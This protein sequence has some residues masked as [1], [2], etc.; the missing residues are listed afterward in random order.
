[1][2]RIKVFHLIKGLN[3]GGAETLLAE[4]L[5]F[6]D[7]ERFELSYG[8]FHPDLDAL[9]PTLRARGAEVTCFEAGSHAMMPL[10]GLRIARHLWRNR[11]DLV[12]CHLPT[13]GA[14]GRVA[15]ALA[16]VPLVYT[17]HNKVEWYR[18]AT[19]RANAW[20][21]SW[22]RHV[23]AVSGS[24][25]DSIEAYIRPSVPVT[26]VRNGIDA[27]HFTRSPQD[28]CAVRQRYG[29]PTDAPVVGN[30]AALISQKR[31][32]DWLTA[33][34]LIRERQ[35]RT[36]FFLVGEGPQRAELLQRIAASELRDVVH[37]PGS[38]ADVRPYLSAIDFYMM[39]SAYEG[40]PVALLEAMAMGCV[41][42][43]TAVGGIPEVIRDGRNGFL[44]EWGKPDRLAAR[45]VG[46]LGDPE[47]LRATAAEARQTVEAEFGIERMTREVEAVYLLVLDRPRARLTT[48]ASH[49]R[50]DAGREAAVNPR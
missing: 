4:G 7:R 45:V 6:A 41:P 29:I 30:V 39:S 28:G 21:Y 42:V 43:C 10:R 3:R 26:V 32:H 33:A 14:V 47:Q 24:V 44:T 18:K 15:A 11:I 1:M 27:T 46:V 35:P 50:G 9:V 38:Q 48:R 23:I 31:L 36:H 25:R 37:L 40:L 22:Q 20:T 16:S 8:Y 34:E 5:R 13:A 17:E 49:S 19:F 2:A 12:H